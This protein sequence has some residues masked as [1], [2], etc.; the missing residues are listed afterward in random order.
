M[1]LLALGPGQRPNWN[2]KRGC[3]NCAIRYRR[4]GTKGGR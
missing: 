1:E 2:V 3:Q 4:G